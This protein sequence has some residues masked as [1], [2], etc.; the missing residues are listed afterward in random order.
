MRTWLRSVK[1]KKEEKFLERVLFLDS[2][3]INAFGMKFSVRRTHMREMHAMKFSVS[4]NILEKS[5]DNSCL[6]EAGGVGETEPPPR[7]SISRTE[8]HLWTTRRDVGGGNGT[9]IFRRTSIASGD[10]TQLENVSR[11]L[12]ARQL[13]RRGRPEEDVQQK[14]VRSPLFFRGSPQAA[15]RLISFPFSGGWILV[16]YGEKAVTNIQTLSFRMK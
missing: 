7:D 15:D 16:F 8:D 6:D 12:D 4:K 10:P 1:K 11:K 9:L 3:P 14:Q 13:R 2:H 5:Y